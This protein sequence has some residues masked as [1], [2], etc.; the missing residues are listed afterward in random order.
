M[1]SDHK[2]HH[3]CRWLEATWCKSQP[4]ITGPGLTHSLATY[5]GFPALANYLTPLVLSLPACKTGWWCHSHR[6]P[7]RP[8]ETTKQRCLAPPGSQHVSPAAGLTDGWRTYG[9]VPICCFHS[10]ELLSQPRA[11]ELQTHVGSHLPDVFIPKPP[12]LK[13]VSWLRSC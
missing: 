10:P 6:V 4:G 12:P 5:Q 2:F 8:R 9:T 7:N 11:P 3:L 1:R 13:P